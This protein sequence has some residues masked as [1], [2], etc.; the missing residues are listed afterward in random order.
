MKASAQSWILTA[1]AHRSMALK[2][3][4]DWHQP[5]GRHGLN[6]LGSSDECVPKAHAT[7]TEHAD[8]RWLGIPDYCGT[9]EDSPGI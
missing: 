9:E 7:H 1:F 2:V 8:Y 3:S 4:D 5:I 6:F